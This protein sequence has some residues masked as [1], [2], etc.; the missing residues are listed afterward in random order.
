MIVARIVPGVIL[1]VYVACG[2]AGVRW[3]AFGAITMLTAAVY[4]PVL[5]WLVTRFSE[6]VL[7]RAGYWAWIA[8]IL[9]L[10]ATVG[11]MRDPPW[12]MLLR[13]G[14][15]GLRGLFVRARP[16]AETPEASHRGMP[17]LRGLASRI[18]WAERIPQKPFY[19]P[20][21]VQWI[22]L[23]L[24]H[25]SITLPTLANPLIEMGGLWGESKT[26]YLDMVS[27][28]ERRWLAR[29]ATLTRRRG[30]DAA[31]GGGRALALARQ[32]GLIFPLVAKPDIGWQG[33]GVRLVGSESELLAYVAVF[34]EGAALMLQERVAWEG[35]AGVFYVRLPGAET[36]R[37]V[38]LT[39]RYIA[40]RRRRRGIGTRPHPRRPARVLEGGRASRSAAEAWRPLGRGT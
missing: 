29:Y 3:F 10:I 26:I 37:V 23:A 28:D 7:S 16:P 12:G 8:G 14:R 27:G 4:L 32:A 35:E 19:L 22:R 15:S 36:G 6:G 31:E 9:L 5:L 11:W 34:P 33:Y 21:A 40:R 17:S 1:P 24:R 39:L 20:L 18:G 25:G 30:A 13:V 2:L 38:G